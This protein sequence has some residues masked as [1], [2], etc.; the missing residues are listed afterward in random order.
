MSPA[1]IVEAAVDAGLTHVAVVDHFQTEKL[2]GEGLSPGD[3]PDYVAAVREAGRRS[4]AGVKLLVGIEVDFCKE[5]TDFAPLRKAETYAGLDFV[6]FEYVQE[7]RFQG[8]A[9]GELLDIRAGVPCPVGLAHPDLAAVFGDFLPRS[10]VELLANHG[11]FVELCPSL[12]N[13]IP[14]P[15]PREVPASD[16]QDRIAQLNRR[17]SDLL[18]TEPGESPDPDR[19]RCAMQTQRRIEALMRGLELLPAYRIDSTFN[20]RF[21]ESAVEGGLL[22]SIGA[23]A[24]ETKEEIG[25]IE[26]AVDF[27]EETGLQDNLVTRRFWSV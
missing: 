10:A 8:A 7:R 20:R 27:V 21:F 25:E 4:R 16:I 3:L 12:R 17:V 13:A 1:E 2:G 15:I 22:F 26:D 9:L 11:I 14:V 24:H 18:R 5:R 19:L 23:D 6:L